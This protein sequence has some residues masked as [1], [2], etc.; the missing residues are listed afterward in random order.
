MTYYRPWELPPEDLP[1][2][3]RAFVG[4]GLKVALSDLPG[5]RTVDVVRV[6]P[7]GYWE[8]RVS[9][10]EREG[11]PE[12]WSVKV[13]PGGDVPTLMSD[14]PPLVVRE[15]LR[16]TTGLLPKVRHALEG[17]D[18]ALKNDPALAFLWEEP[19]AGKKGRT[20]EATDFDHATLA[21]AYVRAV[22]T[23]PRRP[24]KDLAERTGVD[25]G[26]L[27]GW[28]TE[29]IRNDFLTKSGTPGVAGGAL[30]QATLDTL[31]HHGLDR[32]HDDPVAAFLESPRVHNYKKEKSEKARGRVQ[33]ATERRH[34]ARELREKP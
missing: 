2:H 33:K 28:R 25:D 31:K 11:H 17:K 12:L 23:A 27:R 18:A 3:I 1:P 29:A 34:K 16:A 4:E 15:F 14:H 21:W 10:V 5:W 24:L 8:A 13:E 9:Y 30:L 6:L 26:T 7:S 32:E 19:Q 22:Q 20:P